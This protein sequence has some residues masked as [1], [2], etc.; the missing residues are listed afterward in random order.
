MEAVRAVDAGELA[1][2]A[3]AARL[4]HKVDRAVGR[5]QRSEG[6]GHVAYGQRDR[7]R[8]GGHGG[9][10][11]A[12]GRNSGHVADAYVVMLDVCCVV[13]CVLC[14]MCCVCMCV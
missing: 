2:D 5:A 6:R 1:D 8:A 11:A 14:V 9:G 4:A 10:V 12:G 3:H 13:C 7:R